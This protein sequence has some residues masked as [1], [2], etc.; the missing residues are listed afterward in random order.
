MPKHICVHTCACSEGQDGGRSENKS[1]SALSMIIYY[2]QISIYNH[3][4]NSSEWA[5][6]SDFGIEEKANWK[7]Q[8]R[9]TGNVCDTCSQVVCSQR[10]GRRVSITII[11][12]EL[13]LLSHFEWIPWKLCNELAVIPHSTCERASQFGNIKY[14]QWTQGDLPLF[15]N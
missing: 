9:K 11:L 1:S 7:S 14:P 15:L 10:T 6:K 2:V 4:S 12:P 13:V 8:R 5:Y 3:N